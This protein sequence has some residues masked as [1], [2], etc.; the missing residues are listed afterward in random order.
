MEPGKDSLFNTLDKAYFA[1]NQISKG[2]KL[3][4]APPP[5]DISVTSGPNKIVVNW[6]YRDNSY[7]Q[8]AV[9]GVEDWDEWRVYKK[10]GALTTFDPLDE[11]AIRKWTLVFSTKE[12]SV[13]EFVDED[14]TRGVDYYYAVTAVDNG[15][16]NTTG[17]SPGSKLESSRYVTMSMLPAVSFKPGLDVSNQVRVVPNPA[18]VMAGSALNQGSPNKISFFNLPV[19]CKLKIF[20]ESGELVWERPHYGTSDHEWDQKTDSNQY[21]VS[22][23]YVLAVV[24]C[25]DING[26]TLENQF[27][28]FVIIR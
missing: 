4:A 10:D 14:I 20:T 27:V 1:W 3:P 15:S 8:D 26:K 25:K 24:D 22:G 5:P 11:G 7:Y 18:T 16:Q 2:I 17:F 21:A 6:S 9:T 28:K 12:K 13:Q 19:E 23:L